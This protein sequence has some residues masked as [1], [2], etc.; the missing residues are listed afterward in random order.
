MGEPV[1][2]KV[3]HK[4]LDDGSRAIDAIGCFD[5]AGKASCRAT[6]VSLTAGNYEIR[7]P[8]AIAAL[9]DLVELARRGEDTRSPKGWS[10]VPLPSHGALA[11]QMQQ[12]RQHLISRSHN[13]RRCRPRQLKDQLRWIDICEL[14]AEAEGR[15]F[16]VGLGLRALRDFYG[17]VDRPAY[18]KAVSIVRLACRHLDLPDRVPDELM[19]R[20]R[21]EIESRKVPEDR[22]IAERI[23]AIKDPYEAQLI[24]AVVAYGRR[25]AEIYYAD[26]PKLRPDGD[27]PVF[28]AKNGKMGMSW[29]VP[30][31]DEQIDLQGFRPPCW[32][33]LQSVDKRPAP[34]KEALIRVQASRI[35][36][37]IRSR[38]GCTATDLRHR[39]GIVC[40]TDPSYQ[41][42]A[43]EIAQA[44]LTSI[45]MLEKRYLRELR[46]YRD[47]RRRRHTA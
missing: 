15:E 43:M 46:D 25:V 5:R 18:K 45:H 41:E 29:P 36:R 17:G 27:L 23:K 21:P 4:P 28:A 30:F 13:L 1:K 42:D 11:K 33:E 8:E 44:M 32:D 2:L 31:G 3:R 40:L 12:V 22:V 35:S 9:R 14:R 24:Y 34:E 20:H 7:L 39:W 38:L 26:W 19:P 10:K 6:G 47:L 37:L 16:S